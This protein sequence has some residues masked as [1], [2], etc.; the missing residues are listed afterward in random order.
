MCILGPM[1]KQF[2][3][4]KHNGFA[5]KFSSLL[6]ASVSLF[7][8]QHVKWSVKKGLVNGKILYSLLGSL[9]KLSLYQFA[10]DFFIQMTSQMVMILMTTS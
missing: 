10:Y 2:T 7:V 5:G 9:I 6:F 8:G 3:P 4:G 1:S